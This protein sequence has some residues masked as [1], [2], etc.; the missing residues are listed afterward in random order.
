[1]KQEKEKIHKRKPFKTFFGFLFFV[2]RNDF[3]DRLVIPDKAQ[4][5]TLIEVD[6][7]ICNP[8]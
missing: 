1:M 3:M 8:K 5:S 7:A 4:V 6:T 2:I